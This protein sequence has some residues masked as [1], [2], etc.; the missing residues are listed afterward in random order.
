[1]KDEEEEKKTRERQEEQKKERDGGGGVG[2]PLRVSVSP[3]GSTGPVDGKKAQ[4]D[5]DEKFLE[6]AGRQTPASD[7]PPLLP[8]S[9]RGWR[10]RCCKDRKDS[11]ESS[12]VPS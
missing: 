11:G 10:K 9:S 12:E 6:L 4:K 3:V 8:T 5:V 2:A 7:S 1:M